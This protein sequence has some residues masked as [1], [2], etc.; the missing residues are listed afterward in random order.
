MI[1]HPNNKPYYKEAVGKT[2]TVQSNLKRINVLACSR[3]RIS[4]MALCALRYFLRDRQIAC[5]C[6]DE[7]E[8]SK[9]Y[10]A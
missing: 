2:Y 4:F 10:K 8:S 1:P 5:K 7:K 6:E 9:K 3:K